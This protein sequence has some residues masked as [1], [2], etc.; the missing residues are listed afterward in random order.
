MSE[1]LTSS[2]ELRSRDA[3]WAHDVCSSDI[4]RTMPD[5]VHAD[6]IDG[7]TICREQDRGRL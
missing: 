7:R 6:G 3:P 4:N 2:S 1:Q 5:I